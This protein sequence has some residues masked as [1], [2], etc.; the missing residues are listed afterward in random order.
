MEADAPPA[1]DAEPLRQLRSLVAPGR[2]P[3]SVV[4]VA[5]GRGTGRTALLRRLVDEVDLEPIWIDCT[6][7]ASREPLRSLREAMRAQQ[8]PLI[9]E[10]MASELESELAAAD[11]SQLAPLAWSVI[12]PGTAVLAGHVIIG[13]D[14]DLLD[15][16]SRAVAVYVLRRVAQLGTPVVL[17]VDLAGVGSELDRLPVVELGGLDTEAVRLLLEELVGTPVPYRVAAQLRRE[18]SGNPLAITTLIAALTADQLGGRDLLPHPL[19]LARSAAQRLAARGVSAG[20]QR[21]LAALALR[22]PLCADRSR[23]L[24]GNGQETPEHGGLDE[25]LTEGLVRQIGDSVGAAQPVQALAA[26]SL[27]TPLDRQALHR[28]LGRTGTPAESAIHLAFAGTSVTPDELV[29]T[30]TAAYAGG[31]PEE[32]AM[33]LD[34]VDHKLPAGGLD[35]AQQLLADGYLATVGKIIQANEAAPNGLAP[36]AVAALTTEIALLTGRV[37][38]RLPGSP[39]DL[40]PA[41][42]GVEWAKT[43]LH[44]VQTQ[45]HRGD[46]VAADDLMTATANRFAETSPALQALFRFER[47]ALGYHREEDESL[48]ELAAAAR[49][50]YETR[51]DSY[52]VSQAVMVFYL[53]AAGH[54][55]L[56]SSILNRTEPTSGAGDLTRVAHLV[57]RIQTELVRGNYASAAALV[58][59]MDRVMPYAQGGAHTLG[60]VV[61]VAAALGPSESWSR[62]EWRLDHA[63]IVQQP[64]HARSELAAATGLRNFVEGSYDQAV[65]QLLR[66]LRGRGSLFTGA[67]AVRATLLEANRALGAGAADTRR[68]SDGLADWWP[69][70]YGERFDWLGACCDALCRSDDELDSAFGA[71]LEACSDEYPVDL[72]RTQLAYGRCLL[73]ADRRPDGERLLRRARVTYA[74]ERLDGWVAHVDRLLEPAAAAGNGNGALS[75]TERQIVRLVLQRRTN[76]QIAQTLYLSKRTVELHLTHIFRKLGVGRK[77]ELVELEAVQGL[78]FDHG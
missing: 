21:L 38:D 72:A 45:I 70:R 29:E 26:W 3:P 39:I 37:R 41:E 52:G 46:L 17:S 5:G 18:T 23:D 4:V 42:V 49:A 15:P 50:W 11:A 35:L 28:R 32:T 61:Q 63:E 73:I 43:V 33:T 53:L 7:Y 54:V 31:R 34:V 75:P 9:P 64:P 69:D 14:F 68:L 2:V 20:A 58:A 76:A 65:S 47:A 13:D 30:A 25:L 57:G 40:Q 55:R 56:A 16:T 36:E 78:S 62:I 51:E 44:L 59:Q 77:S 10:P 60:L 66:A 1:V 71:A 27:L 12:R 22:E 48:P 8:D 6:A 24:L 19:P 74:G 67:T